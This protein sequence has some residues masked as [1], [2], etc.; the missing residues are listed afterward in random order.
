MDDIV[1]QALAKWPNVPHCTGWLLL[2]RRGNWR[3]R[4]DEAQA[5]GAPG[6]PIRHTALL[7][8][9]NRNYEADPSGQWFFQNG[10]QRVYVE[11]GYTPWVVRLAAARDGGDLSLTDQA[12]NGFEPSTAYLDDEGGVLFTDT[13]VPPRIAVLHDH[14]LDLFT[15]HA[16][17]A[18]D[19]RSGQFHWRA[20]VTLPLVGVVHADVAAQFGFVASPAQAAA[21]SRAGQIGA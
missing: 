6:E 3:M 19:G 16:D 7:A 2:D 13:S 18:E 1:R 14:D 8:F 15:A 10:P 17:V 20:G 4:D 12:G 5:R 21:Q 9:I 11:L